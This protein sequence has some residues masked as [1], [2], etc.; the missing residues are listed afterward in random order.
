M[1][2]VDTLTDVVDPDVIGD[3]GG[4]E[5]EGKVNG[6]R[7]ENYCSSTETVGLCQV[8]TG[9]L[10]GDEVGGDGDKEDR[11]KGMYAEEGRRD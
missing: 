8:Y 10:S 1:G 9:A 11:S 4:E 2:D 3:A 5:D 6:S 7:H